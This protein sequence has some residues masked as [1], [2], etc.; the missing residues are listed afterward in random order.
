AL[1]LWAYYEPAIKPLVGD[2]YT[3]NERAR[4]L[5]AGNSTPSA[6]IWPPAQDWFVAALYAVSGAK[7]WLLQLVQT[8]L[9]ACCG[10]LLFRIWSN[11]A[12]TR[13]AMFASALFLLNPATLAYA[14][15]LWPEV[16]H[17]TCLLLALD[18]LLS[19]QPPTHWRALGAGLAIATALLLKSLLSALWPVFFLFF[20]HREASRWRFAWSAAAWFALGLL[21]PL[22][23]VLWQGYQQTGR[24]LIADSSIYNL[25]VGLNDTSRSD[26]IN[27]AGGPALAAFIASAPTPAERN[28]IYRQKIADQVAERGLIRSVLNQLGTQY[29]RLFNAKSLLVSQFPGAQCAGHMGAY[30]ASPSLPLLTGLSYS[31]HALTLL[32]A[33]F[34][35]AL[36]RAWRRPLAWFAGVF[37]LYQLALYLG[38][39]VMQR[40]VFQMMPFLCGFGG[41]F[42]AACGARDDHSTTLVFTWPRLLLG[43]ILATL[44]LGLAFL[45]PALDR[46]CG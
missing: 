19:R 20:L 25:H 36:W 21:L 44:L 38:L 5:L 35:I 7:L 45:G 28:A 32:L 41:S 17:L 22:L 12:G 39:H 1:L 8:G 16:T 37:F 30:Q 27:E 18:L 26:Y 31:A 2:E 23:P 3:Y 4:A 42:L 34:G 10:V 24:P 29:F 46:S 9:L 15:W 11:L 6:F 13:A 40:Y 33:A 43:A 14:H